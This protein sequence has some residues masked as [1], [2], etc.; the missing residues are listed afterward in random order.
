MS[1]INIIPSTQETQIAWLLKNC[2]LV[3]LCQL[4]EFILLIAFEITLHHKKWRLKE[5]YIWK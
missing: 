4:F 2:E 1:I 3:S 5:N